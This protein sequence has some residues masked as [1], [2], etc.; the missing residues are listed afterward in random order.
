M[1]KIQ[2]K[3]PRKFIEI[4]DPIFSRRINVLLNYSPEEYASWLTRNGIKDVTDKG[5][6]DFAGFCTTIENEDGLTEILLYIRTFHWTIIC[7]GTL[8]HEITHAVVKIFNLNNIPF[9]TETQEFFAHMIGRIYESIAE[10]L[11]NKE[12]K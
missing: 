11:L 10:K 6:D 8:I 1:K 3:I 4:Y 7:Q 12:K 2:K 9:T 5:F